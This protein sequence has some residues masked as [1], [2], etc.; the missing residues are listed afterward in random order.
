MADLNTKAR[1]SSDGGNG[2]SG[3]WI[4]IHGARQH[5][6]K[7]L[8]V[9]IPKECL[10]VVTGP[11]GSGKSSL[12]FDT[13]FAEGQR[14]Y[15]ES[16]S[17]YARQFLE[18]QE[19]PDVDDIK[20]LSPTIAIE[21]KNHTKNSRSTVGTATEIYDYLRLVFAKMGTMYAPDTGEPVKRNLVREVTQDLLKTFPG[22]RAYVVFPVEFAAKSKI[23]DRKLLLSNLM[24]RGYTRAIPASSVK[25]GKA[26]EFLDMQEELVGKSSTLFGRSGKEQR[27]LV[28]ADRFVLDNESRGR[29]ED[30]LVNAYSEGF[31]RARSLVLNEEGDLLFE[32]HYTDYPSTGEGEKRY[33]EL[34]PLLFSFNSPAGAC[35]K[36]KGFGNVLR[37]DPDLVIPNIS[38]SIAQGAVEPLTKPSNRDWL[39]QLLVF[40]QSQKIP[41]SMPW[42]GLSDKDKK[43]IWNGYGD[44]PGIEG[45]FAELESDRYKM[46]VR[47]FLSRYRSPRMCPECQGHR[48]RPEARHVLFHDE[49]IGSLSG[50][51]V[52]E[53]SKWFENLSLT[54]VEKEMG[55]D[56][57]P[58]I[59]AR[60]DFL[61]RVGLDYLSLSRLARTLSGGEAQRIALANQLGSRLT[62]TCYVLD[63]PSIGLHPR[64]TERLIGIMRDLKAL[65]NTVV[66]VEHDPDIIQSADYLL[67]IGPE[68]GEH[69]GRLLYDGPYQD[70]LKTTIAESTTQKFLQGK[71]SVPVPMRRRVDRFKDRSRRL[72]WLELTGCAENN[73]KN[74]D[75]KIPVGMLTCVT[76]VSGSGKSSAI[77]K[78]LYPALAK[79][80][81]QRVEEVGRFEKILG[82]EELKSVLMIDQ[83]PIGRSPRSNPITFM[84]A[85]DE[86]RSLFASTLEARKKRYHA[87]HFSFNVPGGRCENCEGDGY[88]RVEMIFMEDLFLKCDI[89]E[90]KRYKK[91]ILDIRYNGKNIDDVLNLTVTEAKRFFA[92]ETRLV[93]NL[94][95]LERVG[96]GYLRLGQPSNTLSGGE[97]QRLKIAREL[98]GSDNVGSVYIL[99][100]PTTGLHF[101]DVKTLIRVLHQLVERG[102][103][104]VVIEHNTDVMKS[105]DWIVDFGP[106]GG[107]RG[108]SVV[109]S[110]TPEEVAA[111]KKGHTWKYLKAALA[112]ATKISVP[113]LL[114]N[115][116]DNPAAQG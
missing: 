31:G 7:D 49:S 85:F 25:V 46:Q 98:A 71:D 92:G 60:L 33:P 47:V 53:L 75:L 97:S 10:T 21:Q 111:Q 48:L 100:E 68:A 35:E 101:R 67:D 15:M 12:A 91:E 72:S 16:L 90:G 93:N 112:N 9:K 55:K 103:T 19:K 59:R 2:K 4:E 51:T 27:I 41:L 94:D 39:K 63:E 42:R 95:V 88:T 43:K 89:C 8:S 23:Q 113:D 106:E 34:T 6:L 29:L 86:V 37:I 26:P 102:N 56:L 107:D 28:M 104:V 70:F 99:D 84:K 13:L 96:L 61:M 32:A 76:G 115:A 105:A 20:G 50:K 45:L 77:R 66:V 74:I 36:C 18:K 52:E 116:H 14:R 44:F 65:R 17:T 87:G 54:G 58:Q 69:G 5:N 22:Q 62:Q 109:A 82:F 79:I 11:S 108:G 30:A 80:F 114:G 78:T 57:F 3:K 81:L 24:E 64:D 38:L 40:C 110:G 83:E 73:L 1:K